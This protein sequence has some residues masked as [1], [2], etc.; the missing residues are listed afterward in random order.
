VEVS[1]QLVWEPG[2]RPV[3]VDGVISSEVKKHQAKTYK[4]FFRVLRELLQAS[5]SNMVGGTSQHYQQPVS[6]DSTKLPDVLVR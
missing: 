5:V 1:G 3:F 6:R 4:A 2:R